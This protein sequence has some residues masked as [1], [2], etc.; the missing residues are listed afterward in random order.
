MG[1]NNSNLDTIVYCGEECQKNKKIQELNKQYQNLLTEQKTM[2][3]KIW[4]AKMKLNILKYGP[5]WYN[6]YKDGET[7]N[8]I[9]GIK[10]KYLNKINKTVQNNKMKMTLLNTQKNL[11]N[12]QYIDINEKNRQLKKIMKF[13]DIN[14]SKY[15]TNIREINLLNN[16]YKKYKI[17]NK[18]Y[19]FIVFIVLI[20]LILLSLLL[21]N[22][23]YKK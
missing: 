19:T 22:K 23:Y 14:K 8:N 10:N 2:P 12:R 13:L 21:Y 7:K 5:E 9:S 20:N 17:S 16:K 3:N 4:N 1:N 15:S 11:L 6:K 18:L